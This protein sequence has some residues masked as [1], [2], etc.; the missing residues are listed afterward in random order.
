MKDKTMLDAYTLDLLF[1]KRITPEDMD[2]LEAIKEFEIEDTR[3]QIKFL[4]GE[5]SK[6]NRSM[7]GSQWQ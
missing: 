3:R 1:P 6:I 4:N 5:L 7:E 2:A